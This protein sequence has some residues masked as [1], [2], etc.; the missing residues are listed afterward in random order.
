MELDLIEYDI[1]PNTKRQVQSIMQNLL[2]KTSANVVILTDDA[3]RIV[4]IKGKREEDVETEFLATLISGIFGAA[5]EMGKI[6]RMEDLE[7]L[8]YESKSMDV[9]IKFIK[10]RFL[11]GVFV[12]KGIALGTVRLFLKEASDNLEKILEETKMVP[13]RELKIDV[14]E[15]EE[16]LSRILGGA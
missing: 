3:G 13:V 9:V 6:L 11:L 12:S 4:D 1:D 8:Q 14:K 7:V 10:P 5:V 2:N 15:L 16:R